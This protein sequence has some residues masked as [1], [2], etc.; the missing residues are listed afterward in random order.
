M[1]QLFGN[2]IPINAKQLEDIPKLANL[3]VSR[4]KAELW[5]IKD[6][7]FLI[8]DDAGGHDTPSFIQSPNKSDLGDRCRIC[9]SC[10]EFPQGRRAKTF[11]LFRPRDVLPQL[12]ATSSAKPAD[13]CIHYV[14]VSYC[15]PDPR[16]EVADTDNNTRSYQVRDLDGQCRLN[17][18]LDDVLD[19]SVDV[20]KSLGLRMIWIDQ[21]CLP[22]P[23]DQSP[24]EERDEQRLGLQAMDIIYNR[25]IV[26]AGLHSLEITNQRQANILFYLMNLDVVR[27][28]GG[29][30]SPLSQQDLGLA[31]DFLDSVIRDRWYTRS[32]VAQEA[33][34]A[35]V[36]LVLV[37]RRGKDVS[38]PS[39]FRLSHQASHPMHHVGST[40]RVSSEVVCI[41][42]DHFRQILKNTTLLL[43]RGFPMTTAPSWGEEQIGDII[44]Q[45]AAL[46]PSLMATKSAGF[47]AEFYYVGG[48]GARNWVD[49]AGA[50]AL[51]K[52]R[53][54]RDAWDLVAIVANMCGYEV[55]LDT[56]AASQHC[57]SLRVAVLA[58]ALLNGD[59][60]LLVPEA[61]SQSCQKTGA[62]SEGPLWLSPFDVGTASLNHVDMR[63]FPHV[64]HVQ[65]HLSANR[66][67]FLAYIWNVEDPFDFA[68]VRDRWSRVW[69]DLKQLKVAVD[70]RD[71]SPQDRSRRLYRI[72]VHISRS[73]FIRSVKD[74]IHLK[75]F[76]PYDSA[77]LRGIQGAG[78]R[79]TSYLD[80]HAAEACLETQ[81]IIAEIFFDI[82]RFL[83]SKASNDQRA[84]GL[85]NSIWQSMRVD[86]VQT[87]SDQPSEDVETLPDEVGESLFIHPDVCDNPFRTLRFDKTPTGEYR[88]A[89]LFERILSK[90]T[91]WVG[92]YQRGP[93]IKGPLGD[94][95]ED[96]RFFPTR[97]R[98]RRRPILHRQLGRQT[99]AA[100][101]KGALLQKLEHEREEE[102]PRITTGA[103]VG[104]AEVFRDGLWTPQAEDERGR[105]LVAVFDVDGPCQVAVPYDSSWEMLPHPAM[106]SMSACWVI[107]YQ[108]PSEDDL[109]VWVPAEPAL[110]QGG[111]E[112]ELWFKHHQEWMQESFS[113]Q[114]NLSADRN[115]FAELEKSEVASLSYR[116]TDRVRGM[117]A[118]MDM[119]Y[120]VYYFS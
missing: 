73:G 36:K 15:W 84:I 1:D 116:V 35:G 106:R 95:V 108:R 19:R 29:G 47:A 56:R 88:Q 16:Q 44:A 98:A 97:S 14:A 21:E 74:E 79:I 24:Q 55:R 58:L 50:L 32:W 30:I 57:L 63:S 43:Q 109:V 51:L 11:R 94:M 38:Y 80:G 10:P 102:D 7:K 71:E 8:F 118:I 96:E 66:L 31:V 104:L 61:Y 64:R 91:L 68:A 69:C 22:Q 34:S 37:F 65:Q 82:L 87:N 90:G 59:F 48:Y 42:V 101:F 76:I 53:T 60:S 3:Q 17:R 5:A 86:A 110:G 33:L 99:D 92:R 93:D 6:C 46:H 26:T 62:S 72:C 70:Y 2:S 107:E 89:W 105:S 85:A 115:L 119:P 40:R 39:N 77:V 41:R 49:A 103:G 120:Q 13:V 75:G 23:T 67:G 111:P 112:E 52:T 54:C 25:A 18:A 113:R 100:M 27:D 114:L 45:A 81:R 12:A 117:W 4:V 78:V 20:A 28:P 83:V 9:T